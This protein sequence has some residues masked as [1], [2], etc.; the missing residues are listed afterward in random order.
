MTPLAFVFI[1]FSAGLH[2][3]WHM[4]AKKSGAS[5][6]FYALIGSRYL[7][8]HGIGHPVADA[9]TEVDI[10]AAGRWTL[11]ARTRNWNAVWTH[12][13]PGRFRVLVN[14][15]PL[16]SELGEL[17]KPSSKR[18]TTSPSPMSSS[19]PWSRR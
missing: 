3:T 15:T 18:P 13:A 5:I 8:A 17:V 4:L 16:E 6:A 7:M 14:G 1:L 11:W 19:S 2:A 10:P 9:G 12:G